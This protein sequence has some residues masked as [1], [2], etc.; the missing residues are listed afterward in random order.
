MK[1]KVLGV[2]V[3]VA[4]AVYFVWTR[5]NVAGN[6]VGNAADLV[7]TGAEKTATFVEKI[8]DR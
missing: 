8:I 6:A 2:L 5:P 1:R 4:F 3:L 7:S